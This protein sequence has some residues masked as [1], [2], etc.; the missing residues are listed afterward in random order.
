VTH[1]IRFILTFALVFAIDANAAE[2]KA[3]KDV[4]ISALTKETQKSTNA[5]G[6][7]LAW[8]IPP[9]F[10]AVSMERENT[11]SDKARKRMLDVLNR[12][13]MLA[14]VQADIG[15][16][17]NFSYYDRA[18]I[19]KGL[20]VEVTTAK[21]TTA[22][23]FVDKVPEELDPLLK[24]VTPVLESAMGRLGENLNFFVYDDQ[25]KDGRVISPYSQ[26]ALRVTLARKTGEGLEPFVFEL[27]LDSL[28][29]PR[30]CPNGKPAHISWMVCPWD[31][32]KL[33][34]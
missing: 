6:L 23:Q 2:K 21:E 3:L 22:L 15:T 5:E 34:L 32:S 18:T 24:M 4:D 26:G 31:G 14:V 8:W 17:G 10:W 9:E 30:H 28:Y 29:V 13:S 27:P 33:P 16:L 25:G 20:K 12:Y 19:T 11:L 1:A 7:H